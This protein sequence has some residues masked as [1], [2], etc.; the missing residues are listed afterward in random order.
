MLGRDSRT[1]SVICDN[2][3]VSGLALDRRP[4]DR[5]IVLEVCNEFR[6]RRQ[7]HCRQSGKETRTDTGTRV[8]MTQRANPRMSRSAKRLPRKKYPGFA[9]CLVWFGAVLGAQRFGVMEWNEPH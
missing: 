8:P 1:I 6:L 5:A 9:V 2:A 4:V 3:L 7:E